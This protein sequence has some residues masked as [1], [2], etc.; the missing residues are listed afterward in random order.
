MIVTAATVNWILAAA[1]PVLVYATLVLAL[2]IAGRRSDAR[3]L[4]RFVPDSAVLFHRL[5]R[6]GRLSA[7][8]K[9]ALAAGVAYL[10]L[11]FDLIPDFVP[12]AGQLDDAVVVL[13][14]LRSAVRG[15]GPAVVEE[16]WPGP[17]ESLRVLLRAAGV[18]RDE[19]LTVSK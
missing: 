3:A 12:V 14:L 9:L 11:P 16:L 7:W 5:V 2:V 1:A 4:A 10:A 6:D 19:R 18:R 17:A 8:R 15:A 13:L